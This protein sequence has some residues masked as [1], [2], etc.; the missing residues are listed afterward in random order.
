ML[1]RGDPLS[2]KAINTMFVRVMLVRDACFS[3]SANG[4][5]SCFSLEISAI[6]DGVSF[7]SSSSLNTGK[8]VR[9]ATGTRKTELYR[10]Y[11]LLVLVFVLSKKKKIQILKNLTVCLSALLLFDFCLI[12]NEHAALMILII[13]K[14]KK[15]P[16][17]EP[18][19]YGFVEAMFL[20]F[21]LM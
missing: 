6:R 9:D 7:Q 2:I 1:L 15:H 8:S 20:F 11:S 17:E 4:R 5:K 21:F 19:C 12:C 16:A 13:K 10:I 18:T 3:F 14:V